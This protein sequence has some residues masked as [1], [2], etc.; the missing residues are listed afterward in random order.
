MTGRIEAFSPATGSEFSVLKAD[1]ATGNFIKVAQR[2]PVRIA[3]D[4]GQP[5]EDKLAPGM[6]VIVKVD[7]SASIEK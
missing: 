3:I 6:S 4:E 2:L 1:N 5:Q 7:T